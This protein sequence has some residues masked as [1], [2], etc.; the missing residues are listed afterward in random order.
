MNPSQTPNIT[1]SFDLIA[2]INDNLNILE[3][4]LY[5][6]LLGKE[7][8]P[9]KVKEGDTELINRLVDLLSRIQDINNRI[10]I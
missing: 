9:E 7:S 2:N 10:S 3:D 1:K 4:K 5:S 6:V 8:T